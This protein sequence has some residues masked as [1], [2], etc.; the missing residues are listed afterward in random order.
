[1]NVISM[2]SSQANASARRRRAAPPPS[3]SSSSTPQN[4]QR[5]AY[6]EVQRQ[7]NVPVS[8]DRPSNIPRQPLTPAQM[9]I[10]HEKRLAELENALLD[11][12]RRMQEGIA[13]LG[14]SSDDAEGAPWD[15][16]IKE[17]S[18]RIDAINDAMNE[19]SA[20]DAPEDIAFFRKKVADL[21]KQLVTLKRMVVRVQTFAM[22]TSLTLMKYKN[23]MDA[24]LAARINSVHENYEE[25][26]I[27]NDAGIGIHIDDY[28]VSAANQEDSDV[29]FSAWEQDGN[30]DIVADNEW[31]NS[32]K[33]SL[34]E[35]E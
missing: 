33:A 28:N 18:D 19:D 25:R 16:H 21:E 15:T 20:Q 10:A 6:G 34:E 12:N 24:K 9:L 32:E 1:M 30:S 17:L 13:S 2:S 23:G 35:E 5:Q 7:P 27:I 29:G 31:L 3:S 4:S 14:V 11:S 22:E 8:M 26:A